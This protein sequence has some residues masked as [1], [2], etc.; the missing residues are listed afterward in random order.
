MRVLFFVNDVNISQFNV[1]EL[2]NRLQSTLHFHVIFEFNG[3]ALPNQ[4]LEKGIKNL[5]TLELKGEECCSGT[6]W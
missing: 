3:D 6:I 1:Q 4:R 2:I 5:E